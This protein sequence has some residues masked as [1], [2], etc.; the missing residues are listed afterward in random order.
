MRI[1]AWPGRMALPDVGHEVWLLCIATGLI[2]AGYLS[3][4][5]LLKTIFVL[6]LG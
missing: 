2:N 1:G 4:M 3:M 5:G 6:R